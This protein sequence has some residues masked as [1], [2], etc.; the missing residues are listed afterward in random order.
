[1]SAL[2]TLKLCASV[3]SHCS[4][5]AR[6]SPPGP[7]RSLYPWFL[8]LSAMCRRIFLDSTRGTLPSSNVSDS[9]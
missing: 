1:M 6:S 7:N 4:T 3:C 9:Q 8:Y 2:G 5:E